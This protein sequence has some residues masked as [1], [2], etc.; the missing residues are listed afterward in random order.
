MKWITGF[1]ALAITGLLSAT[2]ACAAQKTDAEDYAA[3]S[4]SDLDDACA[5]AMAQAREDRPARDSIVTPGE[6]DGADDEGALKACKMLQARR[7]AEGN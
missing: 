7:E 4:T 2:A 3:M 5:A 6:D 1:S